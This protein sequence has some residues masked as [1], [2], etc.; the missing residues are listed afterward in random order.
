MK[1]LKSAKCAI[2]Y[3]ILLA[4]TGV[5]ACKRDESLGNAPRLFRPTIKGEILTDSNTVKVSWQKIKEASNYTLQLSRDTFKTIDVSID[6]D[7]NATIVEDLKWHQLYQIQIRANAPDS[8]KNSKFGYLGATKTPRFPTI[9][10]PA[11]INDVTEASAIVRWTAS[12]NPVTELR[13][14]SGPAGTLIQTVSLTDTDRSNQ[15][16]VIAGLTP[17]TS[18]YVELYSGSAL[19]GYNTYVTKAPFS[20]EIID[21]RGISNRPSVLQDTLAFATSGSTIIVKKGFVYTINQNVNFSKTV[22]I[23]SGD[24]LLIQEPAQI[25]LTG[26]L[27]F[28]AGA[29]IDSISFVNVHLKGVD[30]TGSYI[31]NPNTNANISKLKFSNCKIEQVRGGIRLRG[32][33]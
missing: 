24:D 29:S 12:G 15:Y 20:G 26:N 14:L 3:F 6:L 5:I 13:V 21:L 9:L 22:T 8:A 23:M 31:F 28:Q 7:S 16:K 19:R 30:P 33:V 4:L 11:T 2:F 1:T 10:L 18:Y 32:T 17:A 27:N 25:L